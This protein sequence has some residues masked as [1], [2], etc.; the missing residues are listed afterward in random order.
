MNI[1][2][3]QPGHY[4]GY[5]CPQRMSDG[6]YK[7]VTI[8]FKV[9][10]IRRSTDCYAVI[11]VDQIMYYEYLGEKILIH[12]TDTYTIYERTFELGDI[13]RISTEAFE[14]TLNNIFYDFKLWK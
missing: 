14:S 13:W 7:D 10:S 8:Y 9:N 4:Y 2:K 1:D 12:S 5:R 11:D 3:I 6:K